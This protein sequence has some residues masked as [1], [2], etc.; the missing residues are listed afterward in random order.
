M[1]HRSPLV[2]V[3]ILLALWLPVSSPFAASVA[4]TTPTPLLPTSPLA[5]LALG[6]VAPAF[7]LPALSGEVYR[8]NDMLG[9]GDVLLVFWSTR[10]AFCHA[11]LPS[12]KAL[13]RRY[14]NRGL[15]LAAIDIGDETDA[16]VRQYVQDYGVPYLVLNDDA[17]KAD[18][19]RRYH[20]I[21]TPTILLINS[22]GRVVFNG[23]HLP[24]LTRWFPDVTSP[25]APLPAG[26]PKHRK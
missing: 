21:G 7:A 6:Q 19:I 17:R 11:M 16:E 26:A 24:D 1:I 8:L 13:D 18:L 10:G 3:L 4:T 14:N 12:L 23:H 15:T 22:A 2:Q 25:P 9:Q 5:P 20:I